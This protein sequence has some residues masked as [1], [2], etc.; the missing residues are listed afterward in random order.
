MAL[1]DLKDSVLSQLFG[2]VD[3]GAATQTLSPNSAKHQKQ[4]RYRELVRGINILSYS[5]FELYHT[6]E[7]KF[8]ISKLRA[9]NR[10][11]AE[12]AIFQE[13]TNLHLTFGKCFETGIQSVLLGKSWA[14]IFL[15]MLMAWD[16]FL[17]EEDQKG[18]KGKTFT[19]CVIGVELFFKTT[20]H[21]LLSEWEVAIFNGKPAVELAMSL[22]FENGYYFLGH[23]DV[24]LRNKYSGELMVLEIKTTADNNIQEA[25]YGN[26]AQASGYSIMVDSIA[27]DLE[28]TSAY[29]VLYLVYH[30]AQHKFFTYSLNKSREGRA[31]WVNTLLLDMQRVHTNRQLQFFPKRGQSC[32]HFGRVCQ[33]YET[34]SM[35]PFQGGL[36]DFAVIS[37]E[38]LEAHG[39]DFHFKLGNLIETQKGFIT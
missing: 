8:A 28:L 26:S 10:T 6:C 7:R 4:R 32:M 13:D 11:E 18:Y 17:F 23:A 1:N 38:Q 5:T 39:F 31:E 14:H 30:T 35:D 9:G 25:K 37:S 20:R 29:N 27:D 24:V 33:Y 34:C 36:R 19:E 2:G 15:D 12:L 16:M 21:V 22:D 3:V